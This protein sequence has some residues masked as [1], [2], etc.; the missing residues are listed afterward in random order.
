MAISS[1]ILDMGY[2]PHDDS[3]PVNAGSR[4][5]RLSSWPDQRNVREGRHGGSRAVLDIANCHTLAR[6]RFLMRSNMLLPFH[7]GWRVPVQ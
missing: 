3:M 7:D 4:P 5:R 2:S 6:S 1:K